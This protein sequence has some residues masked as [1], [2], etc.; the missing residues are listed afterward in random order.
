ME[1]DQR[2]AD[3]IF[4]KNMNLNEGKGLTA[5]C[6]GERGWEDEQNRVVVEN[7]NGSKSSSYQPGQTTLHRIGAISSLRSTKSAEVCVPRQEA[8][9][10][11]RGQS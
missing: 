4:I 5:P 1:A 7:G 10:Q 8:V 3:S 2:H 9:S 11:C 6:E